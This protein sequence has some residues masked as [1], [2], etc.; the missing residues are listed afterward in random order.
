MKDAASYLVATAG[1]FTGILHAEENVLH[2]DPALKINA[3]PKPDFVVEEPGVI[4]TPTFVS[5]ADNSF[6]VKCYFYNIGKA[7]GDSVSVLIQRRY[8]DNSTAVL[9]SRGYLQVRF[10]DSVELTVPIVA[11]RDKGLNAI[12]VTIDNT[13]QYDELSEL[14]N[15]VTK[16][17]FIYEDELKPVYPYD[18][19][20]VNKSNIKLYA[21]TANPVVA[22][23]SYVMEM[24][25]TELF[26]SAIKTTQSDKLGGRGAWNLIQP[27]LLQIAP[28]ITGAWRRF[29]RAAR[30]IGT[31][32][33][34]FICPT[35]V[36]DITSRTCTS[37]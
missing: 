5:V 31:L 14:N 36:L 2:G 28:F 25:T 23:R 17:F 10:I 16:Q 19:S 9:F 22:M 3:H 37:I 24:D 26:N 35:Q 15:T 29:Q 18:F 27:F 8:P 13:G 34:L 7:T 21:S 33:V 20:I 1:D 4:I 32:R 12:I 6:K 11:T 30:I